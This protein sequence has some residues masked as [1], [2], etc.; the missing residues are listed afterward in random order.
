MLD[1]HVA[2]YCN[3]R[4]TSFNEEKARKN[5]EIKVRAGF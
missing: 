3:K 1:V 5:D 4:E 2:L